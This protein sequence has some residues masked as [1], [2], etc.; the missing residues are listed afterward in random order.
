MILK[1]EEFKPT[2]ASQRVGT[3]AHPFKRKTRVLLDHM[4]FIVRQ[5]NTRKFTK[6]V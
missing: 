4:Y 1:T 3:G 2:C 6:S 5:L